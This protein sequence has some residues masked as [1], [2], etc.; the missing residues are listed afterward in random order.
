MNSRNGQVG[1]SQRVRLEWVEY[2]AGL[3]MA[4]RASEDIRD[5]LR[6]HLRDKL[7]V[8]SDPDRGN[9]DEAMSILMKIWAG[10]PAGLASFRDEGLLFLR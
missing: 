4:G 9:R 6:S 5:A 2:T 10:P 3:V 7:S 1:F 8:G